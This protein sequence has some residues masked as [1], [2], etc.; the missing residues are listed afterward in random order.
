MRKTFHDKLSANRRES[1]MFELFEELEI[2]RDG[3]Q[4]LQYKNLVSVPKYVH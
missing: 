1:G 2:F 3:D 4:I